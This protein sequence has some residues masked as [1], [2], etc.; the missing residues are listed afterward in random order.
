MEA[1]F[2]PEIVF[3]LVG[4][5]GTEL[6]FVAQCLSITVADLNYEPLTVRLSELMHEVDLDLCK[7]LP[8]EPAYSRYMTHMTAGNELREFLTR[9]DALAMLAVGA[10]REAR[11][12]KN[13]KPDQPLA[14]HAYILKSL[15][16]PDEVKTLRAIYGPSFHLVAAYSPRESRK[17]NLAQKLAA[18]EHSLQS[19]QYFEKVEELMRRDESERETNKFG[20]NV[21]DTFPLAD[22]FVDTSNPDGATA[23]V[24]RYIELL[25]GTAIHT[26]SKDEYG[27]FHAQAASLRSAA[28]GRQVGATIATIDGD[29]ITIGTNE[30][31]K[32][33][34]GLYWCDDDSDMRD[35]RLGYEVSDKIK[36]RV[37]GDVI[38][39]FRDKGWLSEDKLQTPVG[40]LVEQAFAEERSALMKGSHL[41]NSIEYFRAVHA[42]MAAIVDAARRG[43]S[44]KDAVLFCTTFPCHDCAKHIVAAG[45]QRVVYIEPYPKS[46]APE[47]Y[48]DSIAV[49]QRKPKNLNGAGA[50]GYVSFESFVGVAPRQYM[51]CFV[52]GERKTKEG[53]VTAP[54]KTT[55]LP[56]FAKELPPEL[57]ILV[58]ENQEF[59]QFKKDL[60]EKIKK[61]ATSTSTKNPQSEV[62]QMKSEVQGGA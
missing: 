1:K 49:D 50:V 25:F 60:G 47:L 16:H 59:N 2:G 24:R 52:M 44:V 58:R 40:E 61:N 13:G 39:R 53:D 21:R 4:S 34:G 35:F 56:R 20:Q 14:R 37:L 26:P 31:P 22:I 45:I 28:L 42:E 36:R 17:R 11:Q 27:M 5:V 43:V 9:G 46:L 51:D 55:S 8:E 30:V 32:A 3:G 54:N 62:V 33:G 12:D 29:I 6:D 7:K 23:S 57:V 18:S 48:L 41:S 38:A 19:G 15:K 10:I